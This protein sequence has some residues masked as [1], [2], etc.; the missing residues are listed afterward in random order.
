MKSIWTWTVPILLVVLFVGLFSIHRGQTDPW[1]QLEDAHQALTTLQS[2]YVNLAVAVDVAAA[3]LRLPA[4]S[5]FWAVLERSASVLMIHWKEAKLQRLS[6]K[7]ISGRAQF[8]RQLD[9][10]NADNNRRWAQAQARQAGLSEL[11]RIQKMS[12]HLQTMNQYA[13][14]LHYF[15]AHPSEIERGTSTE[16]ASQPW[17]WQDKV[18]AGLVLWFLAVLFLRLRLSAH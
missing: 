7:F 8:Q 12:H 6:A 17:G 16:Q 18:I 10:M 3:D 11:S 13:E 9:E 2:R 14:S 4:E 5:G 15:Q 1:E